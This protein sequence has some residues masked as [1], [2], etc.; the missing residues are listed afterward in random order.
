MA[1]ALLFT[2]PRSVLGHL[3]K[4]GFLPPVPLPRRMS[5]GGR[6]RFTKPLRVG[7]K[8]SKLS[9]VKKVDFKQGQ[10]GCLVFV[11]ETHEFF[12]AGEACL[13]EEHDIVYRDLSKSGQVLPEPQKIPNGEWQRAINPS[14]VLLF[15]YSALT[16]NGHRIHYDHPYVT[17][18]KGY[19]GLVIHGPFIA[20]L[21]I[22]L[23][24]RN[25]PDARLKDF[26]FRVFRPLIN[27]HTFY[28]NGQLMQDSNKFR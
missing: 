6:L 25:F 21:L 9:R 18:V 22:D 11:T 14:E 16:F 17:Q 13:Y 1:L 7:D 5:A 28:V 10:S 26:E 12:V 2:D 8:V 23:L 20:T 19:P 4:G 15:R 3:H 24:L 27:L